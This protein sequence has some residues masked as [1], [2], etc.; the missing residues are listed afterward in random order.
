MV[1]SARERRDHSVMSVF[2]LIVVVLVL[3]LELLALIYTA[4]SRCG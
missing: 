2:V 1:S 3:V 4:L